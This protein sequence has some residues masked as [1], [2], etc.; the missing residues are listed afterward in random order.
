MANGPNIFQLL[1]ST[2]SHCTNICTLLLELFRDGQIGSSLCTA[3]ISYRQVLHTIFQYVYE[4][5]L[6][7]NPEECKAE[8]S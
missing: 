6:R 1:V 2:V 3:L 7:I 8:L 5:R 4:L